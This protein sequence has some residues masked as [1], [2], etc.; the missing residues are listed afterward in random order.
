MVG[1]IAH[2]REIVRDE[3]Q[4]RAALAW[5]STSRLMIAACT[6]TS[7]A[8][9]GSSARMRSGSPA[10][11]RAMATRCFWPPDSWRGMRSTNSAGRLTIFSRLARL[12]RGPRCALRLR[13]A[14]D[15]ALDDVAD[16]MAGIERAVGVLEHHLD[17]AL[18]RR[19]RDPRRASGRSPMPASVTMPSVACS[20]P[21]STLARVDLPQPDSPTI[22]QGHAAIGGRGRC[23]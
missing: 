4:R 17:R 19:R 10:S 8:E 16:G 2:D 15:R 1:E 12:A 6:E 9:T 20:M 21:V 13:R 14:A 18:H 23:R 7:S 5:M 22:G 3:E 11:A